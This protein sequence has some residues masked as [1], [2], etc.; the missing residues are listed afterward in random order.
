MDMYMG[1]ISILD[2]ERSD[3]FFGYPLSDFFFVVV[4]TYLYML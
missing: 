2:F 3:E 4:F 1:T